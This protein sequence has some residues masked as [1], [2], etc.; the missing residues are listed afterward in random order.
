MIDVNLK[1][2]YVNKLMEIYNQTIK[3][4]GQILIFSR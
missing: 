4:S 2:K 3:L 1:T